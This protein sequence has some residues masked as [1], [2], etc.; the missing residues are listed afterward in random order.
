MRFQPCWLVCSLLGV[1][2]ATVV[3]AQSTVSLEGRW[4][5]TLPAEPQRGSRELGRRDPPPRPVYF[6][7]STASDGRYEGIFWLNSGATRPA[8]IGDVALDGDAVR[9]GVPDSRGVWEGKLSADGS[10]L[11]GEW[12]QSG[13]TMPLVLRRTGRA[14]EPVRIESR[15]RGTVIQR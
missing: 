1:L 8:D 10:T 7:I 2:S 9:I 11:T 12:Q 3:A 4:E 14:D 13:K 5:G 15:S 6:V